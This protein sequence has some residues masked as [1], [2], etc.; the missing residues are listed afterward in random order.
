MDRI[1]KIKKHSIEWNVH[2][3]NDIETNDI[4]FLYCFRGDSTRESPITVYKVEFQHPKDENGFSLN[5]EDIFAA[6]YYILYELRYSKESEEFNPYGKNWYLN[7][8]TT[9]RISSDYSGASV[10]ESMEEVEKDINER[11]NI[12][13]YMLSYI[14]ES[15]DEAVEAAD[16]HKII[17]LS[18]HKEKY[19][20][21]KSY[22]LQKNE[23]KDLAW[24]FLEFSTSIGIMSTKIEKDRILFS[25]DREAI[26]EFWL[27]NDKGYLRFW[28]KYD[29]EGTMYTAVT[30]C[31]FEAVQWLLYKANHRLILRDMYD[32]YR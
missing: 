8:T 18:A 25:L 6:Q 29:K 10:F 28:R 17:S 1:Q 16:R 3:A 20:G 19:D 7:Y 5:C 13:A 22:A 11:N 2:R 30:N 21:Y 23:L 9:D 26:V 4:D 24:Y 12:L 27:E 31:A 32:T 14:A 15:A